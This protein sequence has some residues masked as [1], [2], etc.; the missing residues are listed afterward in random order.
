MI[1]F[2]SEFEAQEYADKINETQHPS[3]YCPLKKKR[4][5]KECEHFI[6]KY[7]IK[8]FWSELW[9]VTGFYCGNKKLSAGEMKR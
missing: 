8:P 4:C 5:Y 3:S 1:K 9:G 6:F 7:P 2:R